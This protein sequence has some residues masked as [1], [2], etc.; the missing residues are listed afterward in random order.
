MRHDAAEI[1]A[2][3]DAACDRFTFPMLDNGYVYLAAT[4]LALFRSDEDSAMTIEVFGYSVRAGLPDT[5][6]YTFASTLQN[7]KPISDYESEHAYRD[8]VAA[9]P[10]NESNFVRPIDDGPWVDEDLYFVTE[11][12]RDVVVR[13][14]RVLLPEPEDYASLGVK[15]DDP[16]R[17]T[18]FEL[19][20]ALAEIERDTLLATEAELRHHIPELLTE[21]LRL[22]EWHHPDVVDETQR[23]SGSETFQQLA[24]V[25]LTGDE[26]HYAPTHRPNTHWRHW[27]DG[28]IL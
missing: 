1:L 20:R 22:D 24:K 18:I 13:G 16:S 19:C 4:R 21:V 8:Y 11:R 6:V 9:N 28:G 14:R 15:L 25:L 23:P 27:P 17:V 10:F 26:R 7:R 5:H 3:L 12:T 2:I